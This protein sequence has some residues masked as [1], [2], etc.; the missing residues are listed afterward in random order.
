MQK[1]MSSIALSVE[2]DLLGL[3]DTTTGIDCA[4]VGINV[5]YSTEC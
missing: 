2:E 3:G 4:K 1:L 5:V